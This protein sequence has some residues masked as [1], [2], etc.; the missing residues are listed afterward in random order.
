MRNR[1]H[2]SR[3]K[4]LAT[5][6]AALALVAGIAGCGGEDSASSDT[7]P[8]QLLEETFSG[9]GEVSSGVLDI[10]VDASAAGDPGGTLTGSLSGPFATTAEDE[11]PE[12][13]LDASLQFESGGDSEGFDGGIVL[14]ADGAFVETAG[15]AFQVDDATFATL[16]DSFAQSAEAQNQES[17]DSSAIFDQL[18]IDPAGWL[19]DVTNEGTEDLEGAEVVHISGTPDVGKI[20]EDAQR[21]D[22]TG[23]ADVVGA[24]ELAETVS[25][26]TIDVYT[27]AEDKILRQL[28]LSVELVDPKA[29]DQAVTFELSIGISGVNEEQDITAPENAQPIEEL[30]PGGLGAALGA[31]GLEGLGSSGATPPA[32]GGTGGLGGS[33]AFQEC[34]QGLSPEDAVEQCADLL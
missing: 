18:G 7:D 20:I 6:L 8:Q 4:L 22:P 27:G 19:T 15:A 26:A 13:D 10:S 2:I 29:P 5:P 28:D 17:E 33:A 12:L 16:Q 24:D 34:I 25:G 9:Q 31:G 23:Q 11:L 3:A 1:P 30:I 32:T 21:L 14:T